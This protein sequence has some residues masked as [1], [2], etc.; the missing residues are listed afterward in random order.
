[1]WVRRKASDSVE[2][3]AVGGMKFNRTTEQR[4]YCSWDFGLMQ[5][6][7]LT[8]RSDKT[9]YD[10]VKKLLCWVP[11]PSQSE[12]CCA[13]SSWERHCPRCL[14]GYAEVDLGVDVMLVGKQDVEVSVKVKLLRSVLFPCTFQHG[15][16]HV[17]CALATSI[18]PVHVDRVIGLCRAL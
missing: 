3:I 18:C 7:W 13:D 14:N 17:I 5:T 8:R 15:Y 10:R 4:A 9:G 11:R 12:R 1:M 2:M 16:D 6:L